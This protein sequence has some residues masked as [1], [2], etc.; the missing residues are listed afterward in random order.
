MTLKNEYKGCT[1][2]EIT[3]LHGPIDPNT[4]LCAL[5]SVVTATKRDRMRTMACESPAHF[6]R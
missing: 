4:F 6:D 5:F 1:W 3:V 2:P